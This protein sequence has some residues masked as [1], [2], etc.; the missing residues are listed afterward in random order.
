MDSR[1]ISKYQ[2]FRRTSCKNVYSDKDHSHVN[3]D[4]YCLDCNHFLLYYL[5][6]FG[7]DRVNEGSSHEYI[8]QLIDSITNNYRW[9]LSGSFESFE[10][11]YTPATLYADDYDDYDDEYDDD[12]YDDDDDDDDDDSGISIEISINL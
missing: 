6:F 4:E 2:S 3:W 7:G 11:P 10:R 5:D 9:V 12:E 1:I 8:Q